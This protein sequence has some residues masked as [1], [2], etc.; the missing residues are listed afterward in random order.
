[1]RK[2]QTRKRKE[3]KENNWKKHT[4]NMKI[5][6]S[7]SSPNRLLKV[8]CMIRTGVKQQF[9]VLSRDRYHMLPPPRENQ[10][11]P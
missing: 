2:K 10:R 8:S 9:S 4:D 11:Y 6:L 1:M 5:P 7:R 3:G